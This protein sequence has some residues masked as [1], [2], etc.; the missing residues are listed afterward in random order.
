MSCIAFFLLKMML[1]YHFWVIEEDRKVFSSLMFHWI[2]CSPFSHRCFSQ[3][4]TEGGYMAWLAILLFKWLFCA[5]FWVCQGEQNQ[6]CQPFG[7]GTWG[8]ISHLLEG[9]GQSQWRKSLAPSSVGSSYS[10]SHPPILPLPLP[11]R[12]PD[13]HIR[14]ISRCFLVI[15]RNLS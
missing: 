14:S 8:R 9:T 13:P 5:S 12:I 2:L 7:Q 6:C 11:V 3:T 15:L 10:H 1:L 4:C